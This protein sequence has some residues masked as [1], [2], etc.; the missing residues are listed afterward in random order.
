[1][2]K[3]V[4]VCQLIVFLC[5][6]CGASHYTP[7]YDSKEAQE[8][9]KGYVE[10][11]MAAGKRSQ[12][13]WMWAGCGGALLVGIL[14]GGLVTGMAYNS[15]DYPPFEPEGTDSFKRGY[16][17]GY[18]DGSRSAKGSKAMMG[19]LGGTLINVAVIVLLLSAE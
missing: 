18:Q 11:K 5:V 8:Y 13:S 19:C 1:M 2:K 15:A 10:G 6:Y 4:I 12:S 7:P 3:V 16:I 17:D 14:G 9:E